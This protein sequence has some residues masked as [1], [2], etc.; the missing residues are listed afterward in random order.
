M[1]GPLVIALLVLLLGLGLILAPSLLGFQA[2]I[3]AELCR[4]LGALTAAF[5]TLA[6]SK[7]L[8][9]ALWACSAL[10]FV[11]LAAPVWL[12]LWAHEVAPAA[13]VVL[14]IAGL[15]IAGLGLVEREMSTEI[16][17]GGWRVLFRRSWSK[18]V[19]KITWS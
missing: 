10:G 15:L 2:S 3:S 16:L 13:N 6:F 17:G 9:G 5:A 1:K 14:L 12:R 18:S 19:T 8:R 4:V 11:S 7:A